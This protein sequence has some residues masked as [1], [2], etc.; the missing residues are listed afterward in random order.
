MR[1]RSRGTMDRILEYSA[2]AA[3]GAALRKAP[4]PGVARFA[5]TPL[6]LNAFVPEGVLSVLL[7]A[8]RWVG[9]VIAVATDGKA[10]IRGRWPMARLRTCQPLS[11]KMRCTVFLFMPSNPATVR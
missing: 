9:V 5:V 4:I 6:L 2:V 8:A 11:W 1:T 7:N 10:S 3:T